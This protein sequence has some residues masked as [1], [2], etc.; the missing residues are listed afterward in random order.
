LAPKD[1]RAPSSAYEN[2]NLPPIATNVSQTF[3]AGFGPWDDRTATV[4][5]LLQNPE[6]VNIEKE[7][8]KC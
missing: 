7:A 2:E 8:D 5:N 1:S 3:D 4:S 6:A